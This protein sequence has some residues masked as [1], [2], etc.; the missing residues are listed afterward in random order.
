MRMPFTIYKNSRCVALCVAVFGLSV[1]WFES[2]PVNY[3]RC[4][5]QNHPRDFAQCVHHR[6]HVLIR[7][8]MHSEDVDVS[9]YRQFHL[10]IPQIVV[11]KTNTGMDKVVVV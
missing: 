2:A 1:C 5:N 7:F 3:S 10:G 4:G 9:S 8:T 11:D 6:D